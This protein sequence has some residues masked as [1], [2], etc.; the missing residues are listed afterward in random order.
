MTIALISEPTT[1]NVETS[2]NGRQNE[3]EDDSPLD[4]N[5]NPGVTSKVENDEELLIWT[6][7][8]KILNYMIFCH[9]CNF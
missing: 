8:N 4:L 1:E 9:F 7:P 5:E 6:V 3:T 2:S